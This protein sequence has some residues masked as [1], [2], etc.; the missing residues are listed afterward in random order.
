MEGRVPIAV[1]GR[2]DDGLAQIARVCLARDHAS[3]IA[4]D[5]GADGRFELVAQSTP[6]LHLLLVVADGCEVVRRHLTVEAP[7]LTLDIGRVVLIPVEW[8]AGVH[9]HLWD[10]DAQSPIDGG[11][12]ALSTDEGAVIGR[13]RAAPDGA[14]TIRMTCQRPLPPGNYRLDITAPGYSREARRLPI[15]LEPSVTELGRVHLAPL[16][17][18]S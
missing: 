16:P 1:R 11:L 9:G 13:A 18:P 7:G 17:R 12:V 6:G 14:F 4:V 5:A 15:A 2:I 10:E 8:P 3:L